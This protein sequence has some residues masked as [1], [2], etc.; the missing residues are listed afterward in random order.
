[1]SIAAMPEIIPGI[2]ELDQE[3]MAAAAGGTFTPNTYSKGT[4][5][6]FGISTRYNFF[7]SDEFSFMGR[8]I[9]Y[10]QA[11]D[12]VV[13]GRRVSDAIN[14]GFHGANRI[15]NSDPMFINAFNSQLKLKY[16]FVWN[17]VPGSDF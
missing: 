5:H 13:L 4:Y 7:A 2:M 3:E 12:I 16:G 11:N 14:T 1:M 15:G 17:G 9:S 10:D 6:S 8:S